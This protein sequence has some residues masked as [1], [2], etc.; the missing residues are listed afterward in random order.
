MTNETNSQPT[1]WREK[2][3]RLEPKG[4]KLAP[5]HGPLL[6]EEGA[7]ARRLT[8]P[9]PWRSVVA[10]GGKQ[11]QNTPAAE[12]RD[13]AVPVWD[14]GPREPVP[15]N[16]FGRDHWQLLL[17]VETA[18]VDHAGLLDADRM[19]TDRERHP[20]FFMAG[21]RAAKGG[22]LEGGG[23]Y[24]T[25]LKSEQPREDGTWG[26]VELAGHDDW[27]A[28]DD[29]CRVALLWVDMPSV[30]R[31]AD[32]YRTARGR[33]VLSAEGEPVHVG[34]MTGMVE[35]WMMAHARFRL[36]PRGRAVAAALRGWRADGHSGHQFTAPVGPGD[37]RA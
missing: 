22:N 28:L 9:E 32:C 21:K 5:D 31:G 29:M 20:M 12:P 24:P 15:L 6:D 18:A 14:L 10:T 2:P 7:A 25:R 19:R 36:T 30:D 27:D 26:E 3:P 11:I 37:E 4:P 17:Y 16:R 23:R 8:L 33:A 13:P 1:E 35:D 34:A